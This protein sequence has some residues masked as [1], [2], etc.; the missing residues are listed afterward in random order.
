MLHSSCPAHYC[1]DERCDTVWQQWKCVSLTSQRGHTLKWLRWKLEFWIQ[2]AEWLCWHGVND[3]GHI[4]KQGTRTFMLALG[5]EGV[6]GG[7]SFANAISNPGCVYLQGLS[8]KLKLNPVHLFLLCPTQ[9]H[10][11]AQYP[12]GQEADIQITLKLTKMKR[13]FF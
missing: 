2:P 9:Q 10:I 1:S 5:M 6:G 7:G 8:L 12:V 11:S 3:G 13:I 4:L